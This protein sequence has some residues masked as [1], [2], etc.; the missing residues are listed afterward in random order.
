MRHRKSLM[1]W[2]DD[3]LAV[4]RQ[5]GFALKAE[6][7]QLRHFARFAQQI[8]HKGSLTTQLAVRWASS[9]VGGRR[10]TAAR[11][12]ELLRPFAKYCRQ[13]D[14]ATDIPPRGLFG[15]AHRRLVPH[16]FSDNEIIELMASCEGLYPPHGL[17]GASCAAIFGL[18]ASSGL[19]TAEVAALTRSD[20]DLDRRLLLIRCGKLGKS[21]WVPIHPTTADVLRR[22]ARKRDR[23]PLT[24]NSEAFFVFDY[25]RPASTHSI[26]YAF[27]ILCDA[28]KLR[29]RG[30][31][32]R[33]RLRDLRH[34]FVC[35]RL[36]EWY[37]RGLDVDRSILAL[38]TY[39]G[40]AKVTD[41]YWYETAT[42]ELLAIAAQRFVSCRR[43]TS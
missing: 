19:R 40:H 34:S 2:I 37:A 17:R 16:V 15:P 25:G 30:D 9:S 7:E 22:Y 23:D 32:S 28:L 8:G 14:P 1:Q 11:R 10:L 36:Q 27:H 21:R 12:I 4:R 5:A 3:Y 24:L 42:P 31:H 39:L 18:M 35:H 29:P 6:G 20:V 38:S 13:F 33:L 41:T 43:G 26:N